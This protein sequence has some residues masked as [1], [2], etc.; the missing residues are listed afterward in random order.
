VPPPLSAQNAAAVALARSG[1]HAAAC[2]AFEALLRDARAR[3]L[4]HAELQTTVR[5]NLARELLATRDFRGA[6]CQASLCLSALRGDHRRA[7]SPPPTAHPAH[8]RARLLQGQALLRLG[9]C[10]EARKALDLGLRSRE[11]GAAVAEALASA[12]AE[13]AARAATEAAAAQAEAE[14]AAREQAASTTTPSRAPVLMLTY[15]ARGTSLPRRAPP[16]RSLHHH[17]PLLLLQ[18][19]TPRDRLRPRD[20]AQHPALAETYAFARVQEESECAW[21]LLHTGALA[22]H[23]A[24][25]GGQQG[26]GVSGLSAAARAVAAAVRRRTR[27]ESGGGGDG[28]ATV[29][30]VGSVGGVLAVAAL[31]AGAT[32]VCVVER[33]RYLAQAAAEVVRA[34]GFEAAI[35]GGGEGGGGSGNGGG[36]NNST[37]CLVYHCRPDELGLSDAAFRGCGGARDDAVAA[38]R[39]ALRGTAEATSPSKTATTRLPSPCDVIMLSGL[40]LSCDCL[41]ASGCLAA[42]AHLV[43]AVGSSLE[44]EVVPRAVAVRARAA[45]AATPPLRLGAATLRFDALD[46]YRWQPSPCLPLRVVEGGDS[47]RYLSEERE[48]FWFDLAEAAGAAAWAEEEG[49]G[50]RGLKRAD[51]ELDLCAAA[52]QPPSSPPLPLRFNAVAA[53]WQCEF[54]DGSTARGLQPALHWLPPSRGGG[55]CVPAAA[56]AAAAAAA[57]GQQQLIIPVVARHSL[58]ALSFEFEQGDDDEAAAAAAAPFSSCLF[59]LERPAGSSTATTTTT[60]TSSAVD[61]EVAAAPAATPHPP[62]LPPLALALASDTPRLRALCAAVARAV[63]AFP[64]PPAVLDAGAGGTAAFAMAAAA[65][66]ARAVVAAEAHP[67][68]AAAARANVVLNSQCAVRVVHAD[69]ARLERGG[70]AAA[71]V[72][73]GEAGP[74]CSSSSSSSAADPHKAPHEG[75]D[76]VVLDP[77]AGA[78]PNSSA[79]LA[80][81]DA[82]RRRCMRQRDDDG[83]GGGLEEPTPAAT[84]PRPPPRVVPSAV[85]VWAVGLEVLS[86]SLVPAKSKDGHKEDDDDDGMGGLPVDLSPL[87]RFRWRGGTACSSEAAAA[88]PGGAGEGPAPCRG[89]LAAETGWDPVELAAL[90]H[91]RLTRSARVLTLDLEAAL[92]GQRRSEKGVGGAAGAA[93]PGAGGHATVLRVERAGTLNAVAY[94][95]EMH[96]WPEEQ[97]EE[98]EEHGG[99]E[100]GG[101]SDGGSGTSSGHSATS[102]PSSSYSTGPGSA[103]PRGQ[104]LQYLEYWSEGVRPGDL[105]HLDVR[106][107]WRCVR[108]RLLRV[109]SAAEGGGGGGGRSG[110]GTTTTSQTPSVVV[111]HRPLRPAPRA[112]WMHPGAGIENPDVW[113]VRRCHEVLAGALQR[114]GRPGGALG[115]GAASGRRCP[116]RVWRDFFVLSRHAASLGLDPAVLS[117]TAQAVALAEE[118]AVMLG[119]GSGVEEEEGGE[120]G[121]GEGEVGG[122]KHGGGGVGTGGRMVTQSSALVSPEILGAR[123]VAWG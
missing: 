116:P 60:T 32:L 110:G 91:V 48:V 102:A 107:G 96:L 15:P 84:P 34:N 93:A 94:W 57:C 63:R 51:V 71:G 68:L 78:D 26:A 90:P 38:A 44:V 87:D 77:C 24:G 106:L 47:L 66:G 95:A 50:N 9:R 12:A 1:D 40:L 72:V 80:L 99:Q 75:F 7:L 59:H 18:P 41:F 20:A 28:S 73:G 2:R 112:P 118:L 92:G 122:G 54:A 39:A 3:G 22:A 115:G 55:V 13:A 11:V 19:A 70:P 82:I 79:P 14:A 4:T 33:S 27:R 62:A 108:F 121:E 97:E 42:A 103:D 69:A 45:M 52:A 89:A 58:T 25:S 119:G 85:T 17:P 23:V 111:H 105:A 109:V 35:V 114:A 36:N 64:S 5:L 49:G 88:A 67:Q 29:L 120:E 16:P 37:R 21:R 86:S 56:A 117:Q 31:R 8:A 83:S 46:A 53:W 81:L 101:G 113:A 65:A 43:P 123:G 98:Q 76:L 74:A 100:G 10:D 30:V 104:A 6:L 61:R